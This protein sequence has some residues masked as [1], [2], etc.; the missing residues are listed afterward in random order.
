MNATYKALSALLVYPSAEQVA[1]LPEITAILDREPRLDRPRRDAL[2][3][4]VD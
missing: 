2:D 3:A 4:L 1:A